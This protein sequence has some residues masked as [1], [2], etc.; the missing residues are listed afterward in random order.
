MVYKDNKRNTWFFRVYVQ[1]S[2]GKRK[3]KQRCGFKTKKEAIESER[4]FVSDYNSCENDM[5]FLELYNIYINYKKQNLKYQSFRA[6]ENRFKNHIVPYFKDYKLVDIQASDYIAWKE[7]ILNKNFTYKYNSSLHI[8]MVNILNFAC[9]FYNLNE[10]I[11]SKVGN[12]KNKSNN[13]DIQFWT[14]SEFKQFIDKVDDIVYYALF[15]LLY[16]TGMRIGE[17]LALS[18]DDID[19]GYVSITKTLTR[20]ETGSYSVNTPKTN[21]S[22]RKIKIDDHTLLILKKLKQYYQDFVS[23]NNKWFVFG[24]IKPLSTTT[25]ERKKNNYC[26][27]SHVKQIRI[28]DF[29]HS[30]ATLLVSNNIPV[31]IV[32]NRLGH[33]NISETLNTYSHFVPKDEEKIINL[34]E[35]IQK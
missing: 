33:S 35:T 4:L 29:R 31:P 30:H 34:L 13:K 24:G 18:W 9:K 10:N 11:A 25:I 28:H 7:A 23:F 17:C 27:I 26:I 20:T 21:A 32:S 8:W 15:T 19:N 14:Y 5:T 22:N 1:E 3:Q 12:F 2:N 16:F 6:V